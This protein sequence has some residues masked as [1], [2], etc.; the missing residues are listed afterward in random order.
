MTACLNRAWT[1]LQRAGT[2]AT[3][4]CT[5][6]HLIAFG[7]APHILA[8]VIDARLQ[9]WKHGFQNQWADAREFSFYH[10]SNLT[11]GVAVPITDDLC[12]DDYYLA[13]AK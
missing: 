4:P 5:H 12:H 2:L 13:S 11:D 10:D 3:Q 7:A 1:A 9:L 8:F 6:E